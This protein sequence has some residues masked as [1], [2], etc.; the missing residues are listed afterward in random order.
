MTQGRERHKMGRTAERGQTANDYLLGV[1]LVLLT[2]SAVFAFFPTLFDPFEQPTSNDEERLADTLGDQVLATNASAADD[3]TVY[4]SSFHET[5]SAADADPETFGAE[6]G[7]QPWM[8]WNVSVQKPGGQP[9]SNLGSY[10]DSL[11]NNDD[12]T[13]TAVRFI[14]ILGNDDCENG[15]QLVVRVWS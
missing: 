10:G 7:L 6:A 11:D 2:I 8:N 4:N 12:P 13:A 15:C 9:V 1:V 14:K 5:L 3:Q